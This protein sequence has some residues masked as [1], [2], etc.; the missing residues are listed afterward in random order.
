MHVIFPLSNPKISIFRFETRV[1][2]ADRECQEEDETFVDDPSQY[3]SEKHYLQEKP[4]DGA[5][6]CFRRF[7]ELAK[8]RGSRKHAEIGSCFC[9][10]TLM[11]SA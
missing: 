7:G 9:L 11:T 10:S 6:V 8:P 5:G 4:T 1:K 3:L 2:N